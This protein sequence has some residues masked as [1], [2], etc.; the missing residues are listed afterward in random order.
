MLIS[1]KTLVRCWSVRPKGVLHVGA[2]EAEESASYQKAS[3]TPVIWVEAQP[4]KVEY[5]KRTLGASTNTVIEAAVWNKSGISLDLKVT[6]NSESTSLLE[7]GTHKIQHPSISVEKTI[8]VLTQ[9]LDDIVSSPYPELM[10]LDIQ[11]AELKALQGY[12]TGLIHT[13]WIYCEVNRELLYEDCSLVSE[14]DDF[15]HI[16]GFIRIATR[17]TIHEW[18]DA[19][20]V[21]TAF[22]KSQNE[23]QRILWVISES[24]YAII[25][26]LRKLKKLLTKY[27]K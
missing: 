4:E 11:G 8:P 22:Y 5:L 3:W 14:I 21:N 20:Y 24:K 25:L 16:H 2:H 23:V 10:E 1:V 19:L 13:K 17:W 15:L 26:K 12:T 27:R 18:G 6:S 7:F 9:V